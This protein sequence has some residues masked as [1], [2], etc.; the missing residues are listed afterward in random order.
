MKG[1]PCAFYRYP[2]TLAETAST[3]AETIVKQDMIS[4]CSGN[5]KLQILD[6][7]LQDTSQ[8][9]VDILSRF[10][11]ES[12]VFDERKENELNSEDFCRLMKTAQE[13]SYGD[14]LSKNARHEYIWAVKSH[15]YSTGLDFYNF[16]YAFGQLFGAGLYALYQKEGRAFADKY[17]ELLSHTGSMSC[18]DLCRKA[19]FDI[20]SKEF[21][22]SG[23]EMYLKEIEEFRKLAE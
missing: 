4:K 15:Y 17:A 21:W 2:M 7:D 12:S 13:K 10:Y 8:T 11:F 9:L 22:K 6:L 20:E 16:P 3:F 5:D 18:E 19:G 1:K 14:G 23:I